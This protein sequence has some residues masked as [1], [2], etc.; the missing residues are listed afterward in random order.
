M[1]CQLHLQLWTYAALPKGLLEMR[2]GP[3]AQAQASRHASSHA[4]ATKQMSRVPGVWVLLDQSQRDDTLLRVAYM[5]AVLAL[6]G[7]Q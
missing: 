5:A 7:V 6:C 3:H 4:Q 1:T 2:R